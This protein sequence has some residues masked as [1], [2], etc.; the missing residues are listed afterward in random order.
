M[1]QTC[2]YTGG[3]ISGL[4]RADQAIGRAFECAELF[5]DAVSTWAEWERPWFTDHPGADYDWPGWLRAGDGRRQLVLTLDLV[6]HPLAADWRSAGAA[7]DFDAYAKVLARNLVAAGMGSAVI[8]LAHEMNATWYFDNI[9]TTA[10]DRAAWVGTWRQVVTSMRSVPGAHFQFD[11]NVSSGYRAVSFA[12]YYP[13][14]GYVDVIGVD[15]YDSYV[16]L[17]HSTGTAQRFSQITA[18]PDGL[19]ALVAFAEAHHKPVSIP[20]WGLLDTSAGAG[21]DPAFVSGIAGVVRHDEVAYQSYFD[22]GSSHVTRIEDAPRSLAG[23]RKA[24]G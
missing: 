14:D 16:D 15:Q 6:P 18:Q 11:W 13:G 12:D 3:T 5:G 22:A 17:R 10:A 8:R 20:E 23:Y 1:K 2:I 24:F 21:D 4:G 7:G 9:G 19:D